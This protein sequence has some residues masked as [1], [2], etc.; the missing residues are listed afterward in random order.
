[1]KYAAFENSVIEVL[2]SGKALYP[3]QNRGGVRTEGSA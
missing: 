1:M 3:P 2:R